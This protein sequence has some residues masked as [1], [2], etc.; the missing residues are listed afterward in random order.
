MIHAYILWDIIQLREEE[1]YDT[2]KWMNYVKF[3]AVYCL[4]WILIPSRMCDLQIFAP[5]LWGCF[6]TLW[7]G[8]FD[9]QIWFFREV[10][11]V[12]FFSGR[13]CFGV[14]ALHFM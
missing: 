3:G 8:S 7:T 2:I 9:A 11:F 4:F 14:P 5:V 1:N 10:V 6:F 13:M 12:C